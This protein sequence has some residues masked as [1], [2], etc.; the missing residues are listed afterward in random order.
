MVTCFQGHLNDSIIV[1]DEGN[2]AGRKSKKDTQRNSNKKPM[3]ES[4]RHLS[5]WTPKLKDAVENLINDRLDKTLFPFLETCPNRDKALDPV[6]ES[7]RHSRSPQPTKRSTTSSNRVKVPRVIIFFLGGVTYSEC[8]V[9]YEVAKDQNY[10]WDI[11]IG[12]THIITPKRF[13][14]NLS[15][16]EEFVPLTEAQREKNTKELRKTI[17]RTSTHRSNSIKEK[18]L[19]LSSVRNLTRKNNIFQN[20]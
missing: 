6:V 12:G 17:K 16:L 3:D 10:P 15:S 2:S 11:L 20:C 19:L 5:R 8:R 4:L 14:E 18:Q 9:G 7:K 1:S 13:L